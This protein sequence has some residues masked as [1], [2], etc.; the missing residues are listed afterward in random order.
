MN[1][2]RMISLTAALLVLFGMTFTLV[3]CNTIEGAGE[4][5]EATGDAIQDAAD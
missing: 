2:K 4:D 5:V 3:A 1:T